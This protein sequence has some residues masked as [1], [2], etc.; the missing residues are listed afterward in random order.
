MNTNLWLYKFQ[1]TKWRDDDPVP[2]KY[3]TEYLS[4]KADDAY[5]Q[6]VRSVQWEHERKGYVMISREKK[7][8][9][10]RL[11]M[12]NGFGRIIIEI[13]R[14]G[15]GC[16]AGNSQITKPE[17]KEPLKKR[18]AVNAAIVGIGLLTFIGILW[19]GLDMHL[20]VHAAGR[21]Y[22]RDGV[23]TAA[24]VISEQE[25]ETL[26]PAVSESALTAPVVDAPAP[27]IETP[28]PAQ[29]APETVNAD[30]DDVNAEI[31][32]QGVETPANALNLSEYD[33]YLLLNI[34]MHEAG[35]QGVIGQALVGRCVINRMQ[36]PA[37]RFG[38]SIEAV[39]TQPHQF[40]PLSEICRYEP[41]ADSY[42]ALELLESG[43][44]ESQGAL[45][46]ESGA[47]FSWAT[48]LFQYGGH[49]FY[50]A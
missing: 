12:E 7:V 48:F 14:Y 42:A 18:V 16:Y 40:G 31:D 9:L 37:G 20:P 27:R 46:F 8:D 4:E 6:C 41:N 32:V 5:D 22:I 1:I 13:E 38:N 24:Y 23:H 45:F 44:D 28:A 21:C 11:E 35:N 26:E 34:M 25:P 3:R 10:T 47:G 36:D 33:E 15:I 17:E 50:T 43:W 30:V 2:L 39:L 29:E 19:I 49:R